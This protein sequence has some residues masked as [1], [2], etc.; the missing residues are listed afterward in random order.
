MKHC[1]FSFKSST[2]GFRSSSHSDCSET[3]DFNV[4]LS[5]VSGKFGYA[6]LFYP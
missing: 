2:A 6:A 3:D 5:L 1:A 4:L